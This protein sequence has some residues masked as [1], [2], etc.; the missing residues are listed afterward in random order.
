MIHTKNSKQRDAVLEELSSR[1][2]HPTAEEIYFSL[3]KDIPAL[4]LGTVYRNLSR[5]ADEN[6]ILRLSTS[7]A[8]RFD[9]TTANHYHLLCSECQHLFDVDMDVLADIDKI[10]S[11]KTDAVITGHS[12]VFSGICIDCQKNKLNNNGGN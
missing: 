5:L 8:D 10:A 9:A 6:K 12:L 7:L 11:E 1:R 2:D 3:K 4:S